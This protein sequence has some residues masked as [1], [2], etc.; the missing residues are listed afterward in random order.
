MYNTSRFVLCRPNKLTWAKENLFFSY[1]FLYFDAVT[2]CVS[3]PPPPIF[4]LQRPVFARVFARCRAYGSHSSV[5]APFFPHP[6]LSSAA[7]V[8]RD[9]FYHH[10]CVTRNSCGSA[11]FALKTVPKLVSA[12]KVTLRRGWTSAAVPW[13]RWSVAVL[14]T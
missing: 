2:C 4:M 8:H 3:P 7:P 5:L 14:N 10:V 9:R 1:C 11:D 6:W 13:F 12:H